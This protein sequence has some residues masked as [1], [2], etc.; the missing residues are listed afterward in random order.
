[1]SN[2]QKDDQREKDIQALCDAVLYMSADYW[3]NPNGGYESKC[4]F[5][6]A[7][8]SRGGGGRIWASMSELDHKKDC[9]YFI[10]KDLSTNM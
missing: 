3:D 2:V 8:E 6:H 9:A 4:P 5:C 1:M 10:A 7:S